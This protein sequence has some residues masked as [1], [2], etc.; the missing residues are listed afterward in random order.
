[1]DA[2]LLSGSSTE[3]QQQGEVCALSLSVYSLFSLTF[4]HSLN[5]A[6]FGG[7]GKYNRV[8]N[9]KEGQWA[10]H[11]TCLVLLNLRLMP[12]NCRGSKATSPMA[13]ENCALQFQER[14]D[15]ISG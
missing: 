5:Q 12:L 2:D 1:M 4:P 10:K 11:F 7:L 14:N 6:G 15:P 8:Q 3:Q 13:N 9:I